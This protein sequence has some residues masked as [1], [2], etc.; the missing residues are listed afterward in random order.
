[1]GD[2]TCRAYTCYCPN[3]N[4]VTGDACTSDDTVICESCDNGWKLDGASCKAKSCSCP[5]GIGATGVACP[6]ETTVMC[7][8]C[9]DGWTLDGASCEAKVQARKW[10]VDDATH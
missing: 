4:A 10:I 2:T 8:S 6:I 1:M 7:A 5:N 9:D 3:G